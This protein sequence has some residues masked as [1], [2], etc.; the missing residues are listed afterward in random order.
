[1]CAKEIVRRVFSSSTESAAEVP[2]CHGASQ[3]PLQSISPGAFE[4]AEFRPPLS[5]GQGRWW[6]SFSLRFGGFSVN[7]TA[8]AEPLLRPASDAV[9]RIAFAE[10]LAGAAGLALRH[11]A[12]AHRIITEGTDRRDPIW[13]DLVAVACGDG[14]ALLSALE[15]VASA[16][17]SRHSALIDCV[18][19]VSRLRPREGRQLLLQLFAISNNADRLKILEIFVADERM[20]PPSLVGETFV[21]LM[22]RSTPAERNEELYPELVRI[23]GGG[24]TG[25]SSSRRGF[26][27]AILRGWLSECPAGQVDPPWEERIS[28]LVS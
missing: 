18:R 15:A 5:A 1:M 24:T 21:K 3:R 16:P 9:A 27:A 20:G 25:P 19:E 2:A 12:A 23:A 4:V 28:A 22:A 14:R 13:G 11:P 8:L 17:A 26:L 7:F 10:K 6:E